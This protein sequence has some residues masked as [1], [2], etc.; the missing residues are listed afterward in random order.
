MV[1]VAAR[2]A[3]A[4]YVAVPPMY[5]QRTPRM[6]WGLVHPVAGNANATSGAAVTRQIP[7]PSGKVA[8]TE[9][10]AGGVITSG[11]VSPACC[12]AHGLI[13]TYLIPAVA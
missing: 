4:V 9:Y 11:V 1:T 6:V 8:A 10:P 7:L 12:H 2:G 13:T 3:H 5:R